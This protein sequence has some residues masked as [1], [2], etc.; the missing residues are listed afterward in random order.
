MVCEELDA[1]DTSLRVAMSV[2]LGLNSLA[3]LRWGTEE[4]KQRFLAPHKLGARKHAMFGLTEPGTGTDVANMSSTARR[5]GHD[6]VVNGEKR[7]ISLPTKAHHIL[8]VARTNP[9]RANPHDPLSAF[10]IETGRP[11]VTRG[12]DWPWPAAR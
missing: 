2:H 9:E 10:V 12:R 3:L 1:G 6:Y 8:W 11:G 4:Q 7:W 5:E